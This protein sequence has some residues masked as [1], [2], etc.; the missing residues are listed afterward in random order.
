VRRLAGSDLVK[1]LEFLRVSYGTLDRCAF[2]M[3]VLA[4][5]RNLIP[6]DI[7]SYNEVNTQDNQVTWLT[8]PADALDFPDS[9]EAFNRHIPEHPLIGHYARTNDDRVL[10]ISDFLTRTEFHRLGLYNEFYRRVKVEHQMACVLPAPPPTVIG[11]A[12]NR[13]HPD[14]GE[15]DRCLLQLV[16]P[17]L[18]QA[19]RNARIVSEIRGEMALCGGALEESGYGVVAL[20]RN[21]HVRSMSR[22][23]ER[24]IAKYFACFTHGGTRLPELLHRWV[25]RQQALVAGATVPP[26]R[27]PL[28]IEHKGARLVARLL[29]E[30]EMLLLV[31]KEHSETISVANLQK[32][33]LTRREAEVL[34]W[35]AQGKTNSEIG[36]IA[37][38]SPRTVEKHME[39]VFEKLGVENRTA[40]AMRALQI[41]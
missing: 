18:V 33:G 9:T 22:Q 24:W 41:D 5:L 15:R 28:V 29:S 39:H 23:A 21:G 7:I 35:L 16:S 6:C 30:T 40:A 2:R 8:E 19:Y 32:F 1:L 10:K 3:H 25:I 14:F 20:T 17:H 38:M 26:P 11:I 34:A 36:T 4:K 13:H 31:L 12:L 27:V 37:S